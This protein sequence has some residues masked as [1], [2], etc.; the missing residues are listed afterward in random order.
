MGNNKNLTKT[1]LVYILKNKLLLRSNISLYPLF[2]LLPNLESLFTKTRENNL[3]ISNPQISISTTNQK[4][5]LFQAYLFIYLLKIKLLKTSVRLSK[6]VTIKKR[7]LDYRFAKPKAMEFQL[8]SQSILLGGSEL[9]SRMKLSNPIKIG[10]LNYFNFIKP[11][12]F[13]SWEDEELSPYFK[14]VPVFLSRSLF[15]RSSFAYYLTFVTNSQILLLI[16]I[17]LIMSLYKGVA[18]MSTELF[19]YNTFFTKT[20]FTGI[21]PKLGKLLC[22]FPAWAEKIQDLPIRT[23][24]VAYASASARARAKE[25]FKI[26]THYARI[27]PFNHYY[28]FNRYEKIFGPGSEFAPKSGKEL[29][30]KFF[31]LPKK[32]F[33]I[34]T[35]SLISIR[36]LLSDFYRK[37]PHLNKSLLQLTNG[38]YPRLYK[39]T[40][41]LYHSEFYSLLSHKLLRPR[42]LV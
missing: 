13:L 1:D 9:V 42:F 23:G 4:E 19:I 17:I 14:T 41:Q 28:P 7:E 37:Q 29:A 8:F 12:L 16:N 40:L 11:D 10:I 22:F 38:K 35:K 36:F 20:Q 3:F 18:N 6:F 27:K 15:R 32:I 30:T 26:K 2:G 5:Y 31:W 25:G 33:N 34:K 24:L 39:N 21:L